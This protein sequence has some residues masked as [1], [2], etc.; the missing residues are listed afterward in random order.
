M[1]DPQVGHQPKEEVYVDAGGEYRWRLKAA[2]GEKISS[3]GEGY[4]SRQG[5]QRGL[6]R[7]AEIL[8]QLGYRGQGQGQGQM[9]EHFPTTHPEIYR[10]LQDQ[11]TVGDIRASR[12]L[13]DLEL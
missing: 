11:A 9:D 5:A 13:E 12:L 4:V 3:G 6:K 8:V 2:N 7:T 1:L 10:Y